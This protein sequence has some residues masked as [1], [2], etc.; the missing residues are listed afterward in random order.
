LTFSV[1]NIIIIEP[2][3]KATNTTIEME[4]R[5]NK[6]RAQMLSFKTHHSHHHHAIH[7]RTNGGYDRCG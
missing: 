4:N 2:K 7:D 6:N 1:K 3:Y 5:R